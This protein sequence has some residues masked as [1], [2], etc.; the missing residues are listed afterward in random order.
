MYKKVTL[1]IYIYT[2]LC[3]YMYMLRLIDSFNLLRLLL[4]IHVYI[5]YM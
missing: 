2:M 5:L 1:Y 3:V 4:F